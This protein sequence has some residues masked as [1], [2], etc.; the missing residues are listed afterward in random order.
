MLLLLLYNFIPPLT[1]GV[2]MQRRI[3]SFFEEEDYQK[4]YS[5]VP[6]DRISDHLE[7]AVIA[8][9]DGRFFEHSGIDWQAVQK[10][11]EDNEKRGRRRGGSTITQ[12]LVKNLF[13]TTHSSFIRKAFE[14]PLTYLAELILSKERILMLYL[15]VIE[16]GRGVYGAEAAAQHYYSVSASG[17]SRYQSAAMAAVIPSPR[18]RS[19]RRMGWYTNIIL[20]RMN[21]MGW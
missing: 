8:A 6:L 7:H 16:W 20:R 2:Q 11:M 10:A 13:L 5:P 18:T 3:E 1:T 12:Q 19:P 4:R 21:Q 17:L 15:N 9:E 14:F